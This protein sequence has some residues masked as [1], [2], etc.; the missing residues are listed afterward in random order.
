MLP[1]STKSKMSPKSTMYL[2]GFKSL[3]NQNAIYRRSLRSLQGRRFLLRCFPMAD[4]R[5]EEKSVNLII[6]YF[7]FFFFFARWPSSS[8]DLIFWFLGP[9]LFWL[10]GGPE[11]HGQSLFIVRFSPF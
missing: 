9:S 1:T 10:F 8:F 4:G 7:S 11:M 6:L 5:Q 3:E 2:P